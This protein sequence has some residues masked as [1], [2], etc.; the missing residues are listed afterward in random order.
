M[1]ARYTE[2][3][4]DIKAHLNTVPGS[5]VVHT[6]ERQSNDIKK[7]LALFQDPSSGKILGWEITRRAVTEHQQGAYFRHHKMVLTGY[8]G[9]QDAEASSATFQDL[10]DVICDEFRTADPISGTVMWHYRDGDNP[11]NS[12][13]QVE[14]INDRMFGNVLCHCAVIAISITERIVT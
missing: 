1:S 7:F 14:Q 6:Y 2:L 12:P 13:V 8:M 3:A 4:A 9:L 5:G 10:V 11:D